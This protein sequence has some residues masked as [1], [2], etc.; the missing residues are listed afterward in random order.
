MPSGRAQGAPEAEPDAGSPPLDP[1]SPLDAGERSTLLK[2]AWQTL[3]GHLRGLPIR[4]EDLQSYDFSPRHMARRGCF[5][6]LEIEG[7][8]HGL[9]GEFEPTRPLY[10]QVIVFVRRAAT[11]DPRYFPLTEHDME[12]IRL[13]IDLIGDRSVVENPQ[14]MVTEGR[15]VFMQKW[16]RSAVFL[17]AL[18]AGRRWDA[19]RTL[20]ELTHQAAL[21]KGSWDRGARIEVFSTDVI[22]GTRPTPW[23]PDVWG[24]PETQKGG[25]PGTTRE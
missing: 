9:Q 17:P 19:K 25:A 15:G 14:E 22:E 21:P 10:Q 6:T 1:H 3:E 13:R 12:R 23:R 16:G 7:Q 8:I 2:L 24:D 20:A 4:N 5:V 18:L 11:R